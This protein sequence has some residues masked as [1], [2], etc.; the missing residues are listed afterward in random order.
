MSHTH[1]HDHHHHHGS[2]CSCGCGHDH[3]HGPTEHRD[4]AMASAQKQLVLYIAE[5]C[6]AVEGDQAVRALK[7]LP[8]V[9]AVSYNTLN[10]TVTVGH[11]Y[12][13][14][15]ILFETLSKAG[16]AATVKNEDAGPRRVRWRV[17]E[18]DCDVEAGEIRRALTEMDLKD[19]TIDPRLHVVSAVVDGQTANAVE[20][21]IA[22][23]GYSPI[24]VVE[25]EKILDEAPSIPWMKLGVAGAFALMSEVCHWFHWSE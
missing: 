2:A 23:L 12:A 16:L 8:E 24:R 22:R 25:T 11:G 7:A 14:E 3:H 15:S 10:R 1:S 18:L 21:A 13:D 4:E 5:M 9:T 6:C 20:M 19:L 17:V